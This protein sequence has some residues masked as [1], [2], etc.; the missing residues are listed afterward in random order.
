MQS[1]LNEIPVLRLNRVLHLKAAISSDPKN[2]ASNISIQSSVGQDEVSVQ[3][4]NP[5]LDIQASVADS[6]FACERQDLSLIDQKQ[7]SVPLSTM[8]PETKVG[9]AEADA[10]THISEKSL[11]TT[12]SAGTA[13]HLAEVHR[14][15]EK[16]HGEQVH[17]VN[18]SSASP[19]VSTDSPN[20]TTQPS[21]L[22]VLGTDSSSFSYCSSAGNE[23]QSMLSSF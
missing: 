2:L 19:F 21:L 12:A 10:L 9:E 15:A 13:L 7:I 6:S 8:R 5:F 22:G 4:E 11:A 23:V 18:A 16:W 14:A 20:Q 1:A 3:L 17:F